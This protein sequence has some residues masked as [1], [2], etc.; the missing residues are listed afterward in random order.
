MSLRSSKVVGLNPEHAGWS[1]KV[2][3]VVHVLPVSARV[4]PAAGDHVQINM[5]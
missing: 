2:V 5:T 1:L 3:L 4:S